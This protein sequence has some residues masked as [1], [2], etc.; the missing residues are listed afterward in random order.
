[1]KNVILA[2][3]VMSSFLFGFTVDGIKSG[4]KL[5]EFIDSKWTA[6]SDGNFDINVGQTNFQTE[7]LYEVPKGQ[8]LTYSTT[9]LGYKADVNLWLT[10][11]D[12]RVYAAQIIWYR[13]NVDLEPE[14][15][16]Q[17]ISDALSKKYGKAKTYKRSNQFTVYTWN[18]NKNTKIKADYKMNFFVNYTDLEMMEMA[19]KEKSSSLNSVM[20]SENKL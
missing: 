14:K 16:K 7:M 19:E 11:K 12:Q 1:M 17:A 9:I 6:N 5:S 2:S 10:E 13:K 20:S 4:Q 15:F 18:P 3:L 8:F